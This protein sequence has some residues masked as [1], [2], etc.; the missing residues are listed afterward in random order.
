MKLT[1]TDLKILQSYDTVLDGLANY[2]G[3][4]CEIVLHSLANL[5]HSVI[6]IVNGHH[7]GR[8]T[9]APITNLA[10]EMLDRIQSDEKQTSVSYFSRNKKGEPLKSAT[11][12]IRGE[13]NRIIGLLCINFY[14]NMPVSEFLSIFSFAN[15]PGK[16]TISEDFLDNSNELLDD[17]ITKAVQSVSCNNTI[18]PSLKNRSIIRILYNQGIF[19]MKNSV[20]YVS[21]KLNLS[22]NTVYMHLRYIKNEKSKNSN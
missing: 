2:L 9:G 11:I 14:L 10:L 20:E 5:E 3:D 21:A 16:F 18:I 12:A 7:T 8:K 1:E 19:N 4:G 13:A 22:K 17:S 15:E 6:K